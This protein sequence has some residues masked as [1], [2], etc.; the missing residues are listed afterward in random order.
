MGAAGRGA[1]V[2]VARGRSVLP[3]FGPRGAVQKAENKTF[4]LVKE[5]GRKPGPGVFA[6]SLIVI[7]SSLGRADG[8]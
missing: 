6:R 7:N 5:G 2:N 3:L 4:P 1:T 8:L